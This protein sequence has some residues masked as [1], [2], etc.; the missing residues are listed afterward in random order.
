MRFWDS[1]AIV[2]LLIA[3]GSSARTT[4]WF[5]EDATVALWTLAP[6]EIVSALWRLVREKAL[7]EKNVRLAELR[8]DQMLRTCHVVTDVDPVKVLATR[9]L[10]LHPLRAF[11]ALQLGAALH[12]A[13][14]RP[15]GRMLHTFDT[16]LARAAEREGFVVPA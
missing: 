10:R 8:M 2:P 4:A 16:R 14:G 12:W 15:E 5:A 13:Q 1:S 3:Q 9:L 11:D 7:D 6:V